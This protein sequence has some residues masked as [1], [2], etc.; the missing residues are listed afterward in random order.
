MV[1]SKNENRKPLTR[2]VGDLYRRAS[3][4]VFGNTIGLIPNF[5]YACYGVIISLKYSVFSIGRKGEM[6][7]G[8]NE[9]SEALKRDGFVNLGCRLDPSIVELLRDNIVEITAKGENLD[10]SLSEAGLSRINR[11]LVEAPQLE[12]IFSDE[13]VKGTLEAYFGSD[14]RIYNSDFYRTFYPDTTEEKAKEV[15]NS[16]SWHCDNLPSSL[17][18]IFV[19]L[20][21]V[22][23][24]TGAINIL[25]KQLSRE[26]IK[27]GFSRNDY[28][29]FQ[30]QIDSECVKLEG[31]KG[32]VLLF[33]THYCLHRAALPERE[34]RDVG[35]F[36]VQ[37][38][39]TPY[40]SLNDRERLMACRREGYCVN[41]F[42]NKAL[43]M[44][45]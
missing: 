19:Y 9:F 11:F 34:H 44:G 26:M 17:I 12:T 27:N 3:I 31:S 33:S 1:S 8:V 4:L 13:I 42:T 40:T 2:R 5:L 37:P 14:F 23:E 25:S 21:D 35:V 38:S 32:T 6:V 7:K 18:K 28:E 24:E 41:P 36:M 16:L 43:R 15:F 22:K 10:Q 30:E 29:R 45:K 39:L 20:T